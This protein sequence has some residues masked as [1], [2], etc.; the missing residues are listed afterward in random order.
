MSRRHV[1]VGISIGL[2]KFI[3]EL[4]VYTAGVPVVGY[5][6]VCNHEVRRVTSPLMGATRL[7][8]VLT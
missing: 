2:I 8:T 6:G 4:T 3:G 7:Q 5:P 1:I